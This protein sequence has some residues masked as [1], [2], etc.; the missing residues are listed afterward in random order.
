MWGLSVIGLYLLT[1][2]AQANDIDKCPKIEASALPTA[3][4][5]RDLHP[6]HIKVMASIG[7]SITSGVG[8]INIVKPYASLTDFKQ[9]RGLSWLSGGDEDA[10]SIA[11]YIKHY[12]P[13]LYGSSKGVRDLPMCPETFFCLNYTHSFE[14]DQLNAALPSATSNGVVEQV[15]YLM[16]HIGR[17]SQYDNDWKVINIFMGSNDI[18]VSCLPNYRVDNFDKNI[19]AGLH[20]IKK[21]I[22]KVLVNLIALFHTE[23]IISKE[24]PNYRK[25]FEHEP[26]LDPRKFECLCIREPL[27]GKLTLGSHV[28]QFNRALKNIAED[29]SSND[30]GTF[31]TVF[32]NINLDVDTL[33]STALSNLDEYHPNVLA[34]KY[35]STALWNLMLDPH[36]DPN[37]PLTYQAD[38]PLYCVSPNDRF[39]T[40]GFKTKGHEEEEEEKE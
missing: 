14:T 31:A 36:Q 4:N 6:G 8:A 40:E 18:G 11:N 34:Y 23:K 13:D 1:A 12:S 3:K 15:Q 37:A 38:L 22:P 24:Q 16:K 9:H 21:E 20:L 32:R 33:P 28:D 5:V 7:D 25:K 19:R 30:A 35:F 39:K 2:A 29:Y 10:T 26:S 27:F 17:G